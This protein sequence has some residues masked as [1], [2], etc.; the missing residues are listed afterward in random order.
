MAGEGSDITHM[1]HA[2]AIALPRETARP[3]LSD[4]LD[5]QAGRLFILPAVAIILVF[6]IFPLL[7]SAYLSLS[8][9]RL[10]AGGY[11]LTFVGDLNFRRLLTGS[12]QFHFLGTFAEIPPA[13]WLLVGLVAAALGLAIWRYVR[14]GRISLL[15]LL[16]RAVAASLA[17]GLTVLFAA[18][19][20]GQLGSLVTTLVYV[21]GGVSIQF[22]IGLGLALL[23]AQPIRGRNIF[24][25][26]FFMPLMVTPVGVAYMFRMLADMNDGP[27]A[28]IWAAFGLGQV[29]WASDPWSARLVVLI[30]DCWQWIPFIF[31]V[32][33]AAIESQP[34]DQV[35]AAELDG[36]GPVR[37]FR[38]VTWPTIAPVAATV[39]LIRII[40]AFKIVD[41]P[42]VLTNG[43][44]GIATE[45]LTLHAFMEWR[46]LN[47][48]G[49]AAIA[50][51][52]F[53][54]ATVSAVSFFQFV[55]RPAR[56]E[57]VR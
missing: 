26:L 12:Q 4:W 39:V 33:L 13:G 6:S 22:A 28:P 54:V 52:L 3:S 31:I 36:A 45:S 43:G 17:L 35:E 10:A 53:F 46:A 1:A 42:N 19:L 32:M 15:G 51:M 5:Q 27:F 34:R 8:R 38:D 20:A 16:G 40:E 47:L 37:I 21:I 44:P 49:A 30:G 56:R 48:G 9:F 41:L 24:R 7:A 55:V 23:C 11:Q 18:T 25:L 2:D 29:S 14:R 57:G 50:Y